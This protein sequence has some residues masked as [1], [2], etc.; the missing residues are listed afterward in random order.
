ML[1]DSSLSLPLRKTMAL[2]GLPLSDMVWRMP[3]DSICEDATTNTTK[4]MPSPV[5]IE[6]VLRA[7]K[8]RML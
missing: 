3:L 7:V 4:A 5:A 2:L 8:L 1:L 6:V